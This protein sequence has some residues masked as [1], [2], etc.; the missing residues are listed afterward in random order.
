MGDE[1]GVGEMH[2]SLEPEGL[3][4]L[5]RTEVTLDSWHSEFSSVFI[6]DIKFFN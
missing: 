1:A 3:G 6:Q 2:P 4:G 5:S